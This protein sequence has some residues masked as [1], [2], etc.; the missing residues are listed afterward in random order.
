[1]RTCTIDGCDRPHLAKGLC[2][3]H[4]ARAYRNVCLVDDCGKK[5]RAK[6]RCDT[7]YRQWR[8]EGWTEAQREMERENQRVRDERRRNKTSGCSFCDAARI[9]AARI[10]D[11]RGY[12]L[13]E[14]ARQQRKA[15]AW[16]REHLDDHGL[17]GVLA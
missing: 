11:A 3:V 12:S 6:G 8:R 4:Y 13:A 1:M 16:L 9:L 14:A 17:T 10:L 5:V 7:H 15:P 2:A